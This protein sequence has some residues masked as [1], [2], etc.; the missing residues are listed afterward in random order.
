M[1]EIIPTKMKSILP[2]PR[3]VSVPYGSVALVL[4]EHV[5]NELYTLCKL[6]RKP[7]QS[8]RDREEMKSV[9]VI[10]SDVLLALIDGGIDGTN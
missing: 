7:K 3:R 2:K 4:P 8:L 6:L 10:A 1:P 5:A 9:Q